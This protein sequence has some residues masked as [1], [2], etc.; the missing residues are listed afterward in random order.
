LFTIVPLLALA[1]ACSASTDA[2]DSGADATWWDDS[3]SH[4]VTVD[5]APG[6]LDASLTEYAVPVR[7]TH[8]QL[9]G[10]SDGRDLRVIDSNGE[11]LT[12]YLESF[13]EESALVWVRVP[14]V[15]PGRTTRLHLYLGASEPALGE[16]S[17]TAAFSSSRY[18]SVFPMDELV[19]GE[20]RSSVPNRAEADR[21]MLTGPA[22]EERFALELGSLGLA[23][24][25][26]DGRDSAQIDDIGLYPQ[27][28]T[29]RT[30][31]MWVRN[32]SV[33]SSSRMLIGARNCGFA[34]EFSAGVVRAQLREDASCESPIIMTAEVP[35]D[36]LE[37]LEYAHIAASF[38]TVSGSL[39]VAFNGRIAEASAPPGAVYSMFDG[40]RF[41]RVGGREH[42]DYFRGSMDHLAITADTLTADQ[43]K[44]EHGVFSGELVSVGIAEPLEP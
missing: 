42:Q 3:W 17:S 33:F 8:R 34:V 6:P 32:S 25:F 43:L 9:T 40:A 36:E 37:T 31:S 20:F 38:D 26:R 27:A 18:V 28:N 21:P 2:F 22:D 24:S 1:Q 13:T 41:A 29:R 15:Q 12:H 19:A 7:L 30:Y 4:R 11:V 23:S 14:E 35:Y 5:I 16:A 10:I 39:A 44:F